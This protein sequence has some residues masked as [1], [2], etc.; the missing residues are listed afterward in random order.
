MCGGFAEITLPVY[1]IPAVLRKRLFQKPV[2][3]A[4]PPSEWIVAVRTACE[5][6]LCNLR[7]GFGGVMVSLI[8]VHD[9][10]THLSRAFEHHAIYFTD[11]RTKHVVLF[12]PP[13]QVGGIFGMGVE[14]F[15]VDA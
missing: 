1:V 3:P 15:S 8:E 12:H 11:V 2:F 13:G 14:E 9:V 10:W 4:F 7:Y 6:Y 5:R